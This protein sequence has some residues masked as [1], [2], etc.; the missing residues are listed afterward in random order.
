M[1]SR[2][3]LAV[4]VLALVAL[5]LVS[6]RWSASARQSD[7]PTD[8]YPML[9]LQLTGAA[10]RG[11]AGGSMWL[12]QGEWVEATLFTGDRSAP[13]TS[14]CT[15]GVRM[16]VPGA[17][18]G[19]PADEHPAVAWTVA[20]RLVELAGDTATIDLRWRRAPSAS[21]VEPSTS[22]ERHLRWKV[23]EGGLTVLDAV[24]AAADGGE[25]PSMA[26]TAEFG[27]GSAF[28]FRDAGIAYDTWLVQTL[29]S[30]ETTTHHVRTSGQQGEAVTMMFPRVPLDGLPTSVPPLDL[31]VSGEIRGR[32][33]TDGSIEVS[34]DAFRYVMTREAS[35]ATGTGGRSHLRMALG[36]T[37]EFTAV[38]M[39]GNVQGHD[40]A[41][42]MAP[43]PTAIRIRASR[44]W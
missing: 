7:R 35:L 31:K 38:P 25:C 42:L 3:R 11:G 18:Q 1:R 8:I 23:S 26:V 19:I 24:H 27:I 44:L 16:T 41:Q 17:R 6:P 37:V 15:G 21:D 4:A 40:L 22:R 30:G 14:F 33:R 10:A 12:T 29:P 9:T 32:L 36:E 39:H 13:T 34:V 43:A 20:A 5:G 28:E 2:A